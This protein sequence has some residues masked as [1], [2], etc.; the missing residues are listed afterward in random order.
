MPKSNF[1]KF[2]IVFSVGFSIGVGLCGLDYLLASKGIGKSTQEFGVG[3]L[4]GVSLFVM[5]LSAL[6]LVTTLVAGLVTV[7]VRSLASK[8]ADHEPIRLFDKDDKHK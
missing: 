5:F 8:P 3:P 1:L 6:G 7:I 2:V 4:D